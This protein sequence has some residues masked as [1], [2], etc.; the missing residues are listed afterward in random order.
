MDEAERKKEESP[1]R[2]AV[3]TA[4]IEAAER[5]AMIVDLRDAEAARLEIVNELIEPVFRDVPAE[6]ADL[7][8]RGVSTGPSPRLWID[9]VTHVAMARDKR[10]YRLLTDTLHGRR[11]L[12]ESSEP[13]VI[14]EAITGYV[15]RRLVAREQ[16]LATVSDPQP[17]SRRPVIVGFVIGIL[18]GA[19]VV[20]LWLLTQP[21]LR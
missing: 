10:T 14:A 5:S 21:A 9:M 8:D 3:R 6:H 13:A 18:F 16:L 19:A 1:L 17:T 20:G 2:D 15:A 11:V 12:A 4:R 7:F